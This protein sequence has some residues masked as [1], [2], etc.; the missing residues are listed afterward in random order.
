MRP[1]RGEYLAE[2]ILTSQCSGAEDQNRTGDTLIFSQV[3]YQLSY[4]G[5][6]IALRSSLET[7]MHKAAGVCTLGRGHDGRI[8]TAPKG[9]V[10]IWARG[11]AD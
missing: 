2:R 3:L 5:T 10:K 8:V 6:Q 4:L 11:R 1:T 7:H 9:R